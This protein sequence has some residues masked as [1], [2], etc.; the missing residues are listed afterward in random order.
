[1]ISSKRNDLGNICKI[2][3]VKH[4]C[5]SVSRTGNRVLARSKNAHMDVKL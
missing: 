3:F 1:M 4:K 2:Y 5:E